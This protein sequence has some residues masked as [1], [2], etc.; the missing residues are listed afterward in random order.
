MTRRSGDG[1]TQ[2]H[3]ITHV[4]KTRRSWRYIR[5]RRIEGILKLKSRQL[6]LTENI[7]FA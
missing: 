6:K 3:K 4:L 7:H 2:E 5:L 1:E